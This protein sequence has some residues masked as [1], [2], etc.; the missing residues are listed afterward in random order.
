MKCE[1]ETTKNLALAVNKTTIEKHEEAKNELFKAEQERSKREKQKFEQEIQYQ[2]KRCQNLEIKALTAKEDARIAK[3][4]A[5][6]REKNYKIKLQKTYETIL[7]L[8]EKMEPKQLSAPK[9]SHE[10]T[11]PSQLSTA[12]ESPIRFQEPP[13]SPPQNSPAKKVTRKRPATST[14]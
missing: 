6:T 2:K 12:Q 14:Q 5:K 3:E 11:T 10:I 1:A 9:N 13:A 7:E 4:D 8:E